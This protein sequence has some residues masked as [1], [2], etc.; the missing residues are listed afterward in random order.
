MYC[1][2]PPVELPTHESHPRV[3]QMNQIKGEIANVEDE[4][5]RVVGDDR[6]VV[7]D[8]QLNIVEAVI[9]NV[10]LGNYFSSSVGALKH[11]NS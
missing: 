5:V 8:A 6:T 11:L 3:V 2:S 7:S 4:E 10:Y 1:F 9:E